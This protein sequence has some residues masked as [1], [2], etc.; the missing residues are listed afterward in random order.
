M[1]NL[2][3]IEYRP[4]IFEAVKRANDQLKRCYRVDRVSHASTFQTVGIFVLLRNIRRNYSRLV[5]F[6][7]GRIM[8]ARRP[9]QIDENRRNRVFTRG[10][11][12]LSWEP[13]RGIIREKRRDLWNR[14][15]LRKKKQVFLV[16]NLHTFP[17][18]GSRRV[19]WWS[20]I[21]LLITQRSPFQ[22]Q[23]CSFFR[24]G[25]ILFYRI[26]LC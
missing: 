10:W 12:H 13:S 6:V 4:C 9:G 20:K 15:E 7:H 5:N 17:R 8:K 18:G 19:K 11:H 21:A 26:F 16:Q 23:F 24:E 3:R 1:E 2:Y 22:L 25:G 14:R